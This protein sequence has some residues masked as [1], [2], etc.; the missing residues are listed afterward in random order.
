MTSDSDASRSSLSDA[1]DAD[2][3]AHPLDA[4]LSA[5]AASKQQAAGSGRD[6]AG[7]GPN[8]EPVSGGPS[9]KKRQRETEPTAAPPAK[10]ARPVGATAAAPAAAAQRK[11][12]R[13]PESGPE[14][15]E[16]AGGGSEGYDIDA[17]IEAA[18]ASEGGGSSEPS[19]YTSSSG[20]DESEGESVCEAG[21][22]PAPPKTGCWLGC[23]PFCNNWVRTVGRRPA[24]RKWGGRLACFLDGG[25]LPHTRLPTLHNKVA[26][27]L[28]RI[29]VGVSG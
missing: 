19:G 14:S 29:T 15:G 3:G 25:Q 6:G 4:V 27:E 10:A 12:Q 2:E 9:G 11:R 1:S 17:D 26:Q 21:W 28:T 24:K 18:A 5:R 7:P 23:Q 13:T 8:S 16:V 22:V 20:T